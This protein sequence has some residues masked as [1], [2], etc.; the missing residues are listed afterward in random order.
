MDIVL[1]YSNSGN[2][3]HL[4]SK[5]FVS[6][7]EKK[8]GRGGEERRREEGEEGEKGEGSGVAAYSRNPKQEV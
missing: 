3:I 6:Q 5:C 8:E 2:R 1:K 7:R 4:G